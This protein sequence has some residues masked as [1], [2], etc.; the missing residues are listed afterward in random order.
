MQPF[1]ALFIFVLLTIQLQ[2]CSGESKQTPEIEQASAIANTEN[3][4]WIV[5]ELVIKW[6][7]NKDYCIETLEAMP[8]EAFN[9]A[10]AD[11]MQSF[12]EQA[13]HIVS[14]MHWQMEKLGF[15]ELP[16]YKDATK[17]QTIESYI[18]LFDY[19]ITELKSMN[20]EDL[21]ET[22]GVFY[23]ESSKRRLLTLLDNHVTHHRGEM[24]V[25]L[26]LKGIKPPKFRGW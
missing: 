15:D 14:T 18:A 25:Y 17:A 9:F 5:D 3:L 1:Y 16:E 23:G 7:N 24:I 2:S 8:E 21:Q 4:D 12:S 10:P 22:V 19:L 6:T 20:S 26:R 11:S 13:A